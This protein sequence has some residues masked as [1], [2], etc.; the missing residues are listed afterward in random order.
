MS[1]PS[2]RVV[3][4]YPLFRCTTCHHEL[5]LLQGHIFWGRKTLCNKIDKKFLEKI[6]GVE[7]VEEEK[8]TLQN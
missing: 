1:L 7:S 6:P 4:T 3:T 5:L 8:F 2:Y